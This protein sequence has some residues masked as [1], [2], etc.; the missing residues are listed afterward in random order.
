VIQLAILKEKRDKMNTLK[1]Q[2]EENGFEKVI[3]DFNLIS[4]EDDNY[5]LL[6]YQQTKSPLHIKS[7]KQS[8]GIIFNKETLDIVSYPFIKF[9][10]IGKKHKL[11]LK[12]FKVYEKTDGTMIQLWFCKIRDKWIVSTT[13]AVE[14]N[15]PLNDE[16]TKT[17]TDLF[18][19]T[20]DDIGYDMSKLI[21]GKTYIF[22][23]ATEMNKVVNT[24]E[25]RKIVLIGV[26]DLFT[27]EEESL[28]HYSLTLGIPQPRE[29]HFDTFED[30]YK[31]LKNVKLGDV[32]FE[33]YVLVNH[34]TFERYKVKSNTYIVFHQFNG[35][36]VDKEGFS[37]ER[38]LDVV[39]AGEI[40][41]VATV[42][43]TLLEPLKEIETKVN[44]I[45][46]SIKDDFERIR[47]IEDKKT[48]FLE[49]QKVV[50]FNK[51]FKSILTVFNILN[52]ERSISFDDAFNRL[53]TKNLYKTLKRYKIG[54]L[55]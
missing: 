36:D 24:F 26:R 50:K 18:W 9:P 13:G 37:K 3:K 6:K 51:S 17:F 12:N 55:K 29:Y 15:H 11:D 31:S 27:L 41:E 53:D 40:D 20:C 39:R 4:K 30:L 2:I 49:S 1:R 38:L 8:R 34:N 25:K 14:A 33:G 16:T 5:I 22:E 46:D 10:T 28:S 35:E 32:N 23:L 42:F 52:N 43:P 54:D 44:D 45:K 7:V 21:K 48:F 19:E 47:L